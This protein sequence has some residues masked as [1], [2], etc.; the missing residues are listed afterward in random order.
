[1]TVFSVI[2]CRVRFNINIIHDLTNLFRLQLRKTGLLP[3]NSF[4]FDFDQEFDF[5]NFEYP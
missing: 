3:A 4:G 1:M 2:S 5:Q